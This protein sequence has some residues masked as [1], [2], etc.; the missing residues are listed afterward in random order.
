MQ[1]HFRTTKPKTDSNQRAQEVITDL[2]ERLPKENHAEKNVPIV[3][4]ESMKAEISLKLRDRLKTSNGNTARPTA[5]RKPRGLLSQQPKNKKNSWKLKTFQRGTSHWDNR[6]PHTLHLIGTQQSKALDAAAQFCLHINDEMM[7]N[8]EFSSEDISKVGYCEDT[9]EFRPTMSNRQ[10]T[11]G[12]HHISF[13]LAHEE[14]VEEVVRYFRDLSLKIVTFRDTDPTD[15]KINPFQYFRN[16]KSPQ[17]LVEDPA[18]TP[19]EQTDEEFAMQL[20]SDSRRR[21]A[22]TNTSMDS[23]TVE[24]RSTRSKARRPQENKNQ[25]ETKETHSIARPKLD[26]PCPEWKTPLLYP[27]QGQKRANVEYGDLRRLRGTEFLNDNLINFYLRYLEED[28]LKNNPQLARE[29]HFFN[30]FFY[31][32]LKMKGNTGKGMQGILKWTSKI[33]LFSKNY[34]I[35]PIC[36]NA[37]W[38]LAVVCNLQHLQRKLQH[39]SPVEEDSREDSDTTMSTEKPQI[40]SK[41]SEVI[42][43]NLDILDTESSAERMILD[44]E[45]PVDDENETLDEAIETKNKTAIINI[46]ESSSEASTPRLKAKTSKKAVITKRNWLS[47]DTPAIIILDSMGCGSS[48]RPTTSKNIKEWLQTEAKEKRGIAINTKDDI[49]AMYPKSPNQ[50]N[51]YDC[52]LFVLHYA[53]RFLARAKDFLSAFL[54]KD[55]H[56]EKELWQIDDIV[57]M[58]ERMFNMIIDLHTKFEEHNERTRIEQGSKS[59][60]SDKDLDMENRA[61]EIEKDIMVSGQVT[62]EPG[63]PDGHNAEDRDCSVQ[64]EHSRES[65][66]TRR[67]S[68]EL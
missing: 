16:I 24:S 30:T 28:L 32:R 25:D 3:S 42:P 13:C 10:S 38:Y 35:I 58:R 29:T 54:C 52:G 34:I 48:R 49:R 56:I 57:N 50:T 66:N 22:R 11:P 51:Y 27:F 4:S 31:E 5:S 68:I 43:G 39:D 20:Q 46:D 33:D 26:L 8:T 6:S 59:A 19:P 15:P 18:D 61:G 62:N 14:D 41:N 17:P 1:P 44:E 21:S 60:A 36:E 67:R 45:W 12:G 23:I 7:E 2:L 65:E 53:E 64:S 40:S 9:R 55:S 37:H 63:A 47:A